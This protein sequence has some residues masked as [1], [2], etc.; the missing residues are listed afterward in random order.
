MDKAAPADKLRL[1]SAAYRGFLITD[2]PPPY[3]RDQTKLTL[4][5]THRAFS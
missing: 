5:I 1:Y 3:R 4:V 2:A